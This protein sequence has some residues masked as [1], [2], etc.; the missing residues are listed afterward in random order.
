MTR[1]PLVFLGI[2]F[3]LA[4]TWTGVILTN[5]VSYGA[6]APVVDENEGKAF[7]E[8]I[9]GVAAQGKMV[10]QDLGCV[11]CHTQ[12]VRAPGLGVD[13]DRK[14]GERGSVARD[15]IREARVLIGSDRT[16]PDLRNIGA[17]QSDAAWHYQH[18]YDP[19][20]TSPNSIMPAYK[21]LFEKKKIIGQPSP[22]AMKVPVETGYEVVPTARGQA[23]VAY[24][25]SL[26]DSYNYP[27]EAKRAYVEP[28]EPS[29]QQEK[30]EGHK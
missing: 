30:G 15:Y 24:L 16:G 7:P 3:A 2:F 10:Y 26:K 27:E 28:K 5:Q 17:R 1:T 13:I 21:F 23:L 9:S 6:L 12:Q 11:Y 20:S 22:V 18:L 29:K 25:L 19:R 8:A 4:F 14:W